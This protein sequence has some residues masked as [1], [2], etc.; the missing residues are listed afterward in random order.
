MILYPE[1]RKVVFSNNLVNEGDFFTTLGKRVFLFL[2]ECYENN[3][4]EL[5]DFNSAFNAEEVGRITKMKIQRMDLPE[6][7][8][9]VL[10]ESISSLQ[11]SVRKKNAENVSTISDLNNLINSIRNKNKEG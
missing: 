11:S 1:H 9:S 2:K 6:N 10:R 7:G 4:N 3:G 5:S 8:I